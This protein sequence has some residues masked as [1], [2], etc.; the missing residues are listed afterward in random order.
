MPAEPSIAPAARRADARVL[1]AVGTGHFFSHFY[2]IVLPPLFPL[3]KEDLAVGYAA[4]GLLLSAANLAS[5]ALQVPV[6]FLVDRFGAR[7]LLVL[8]LGLMSGAIAAAGLVAS[9]AGLLALM[10]VL[11]VG[12]S[13]FHPADY[14]ILA[15]RISPGRLGRAFGVHTFAGH[16]GSA[17]APATVVF[18][19]GLWSWRA[20][21][22]LVGLCGLGAMLPVL[23][24]G[25]ALGLDVHRAARTARRDEPGADSPPAPARGGPRLLLSRPML[26]LF[27]Y[28][29]LSSTAAGGLHGFTVTALVEVHGA[30]L[31]VA[32]AALTALLLA[33]AAGILTG[34]R[35]AD[36]TARHDLVI[37][38]GL[39][40][41]AGVL[42]TIGLVPLP[43]LAVVG[44]MAL[45]GLARGS[46][47]P[48]RDMMVRAAAPAGS[49]GIVFGFVTAGMNV[50]GAL[51]PVVFGWLV[52]RGA[53]GW[54]F[55]LAAL[56]M[57]FALAAA[58]LVNRRRR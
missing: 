46:I 48:S 45:V 40:G 13:V 51:A 35:L 21:L 6:G 33:S 31:A 55:I 20:A 32:N 42:A 17:V 38:G 34:G 15:A 58:L 2:A 7:L 50:G 23:A 11:G 41:A 26:L 30:D 1:A 24:R 36:R 27:L 10:V 28:M 56:A 37:A 4:L 29:V 49:V 14:A 44:A 19:T 16:V 57:L 5:T 12:N 9:Y 43:S 52:D 47:Q 39:A 18:L 25:R 53:G 3:M 22:V 8:G 54:A